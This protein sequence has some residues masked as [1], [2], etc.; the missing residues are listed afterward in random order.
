MRAI[1][2]AFDDCGAAWGKLYPTMLG[3]LKRGC[4]LIVPTSD[5]E[6]MPDLQLEIEIKCHCCKR[7]T[8][9]IMK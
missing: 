6:L 5:A 4:V 9:I 1:Q 7:K 8:S 3:V 2:C